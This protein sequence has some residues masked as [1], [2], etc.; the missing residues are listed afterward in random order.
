MASIGDYW[1]SQTIERII[2]LLCEY[3]VLFPATFSEMKGLVGELGEMKIPL[4][5][6]ARPIR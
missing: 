1:D 6:N 5:P 4:K 3:S 2:E